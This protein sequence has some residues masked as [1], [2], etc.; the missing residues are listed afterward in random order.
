MNTATLPTVIATLLA[1]SSLPVSA[2]AQ[3]PAST[4]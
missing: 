2:Q 1:I 4:R 3:M